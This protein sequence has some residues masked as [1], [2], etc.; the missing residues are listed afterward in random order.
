MSN[1]FTL[2]NEIDIYHQEPAWKRVKQSSFSDEIQNTLFPSLDSAELDQVH[3]N[4]NL[5]DDAYYPTDTTLNL[6]RT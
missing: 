1:P 2:Q 6:Y 5:S 3:A 4:Q